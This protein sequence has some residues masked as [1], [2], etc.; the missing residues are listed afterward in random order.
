MHY[1]HSLVPSHENGN[2]GIFRSLILTLTVTAEQISELFSIMRRIVL[3]KSRHLGI[4]IIPSMAEIIKR[5]DY[6]HCF[7]SF[8]FDT[9]EVTKIVLPKVLQN[10]ILFLLAQGTA[11]PKRFFL[12]SRVTYNT[13]RD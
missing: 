9:P 2:V 6:S 5:V 13:G 3:K 8:F 1:Y 10:F 7:E 4:S 11:E 12:F